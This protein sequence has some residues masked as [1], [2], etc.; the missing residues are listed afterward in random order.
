M[1]AKDQIDLLKWLVAR[2]DSMRA[3][4]SNRAAMILSADA[5]ILAAIAFLLDKSITTTTQPWHYSLK[6]FAFASLVLMTISFVLAL[7]ASIAYRHSR[8]TAHFTGPSRVFL[9]TRETFDP[10]VCPD[11]ATFKTKFDA[12]TEASFIESACAEL[13]VDL[14][15]QQIRYGRLKKS[16]LFIL[17]A[18]L[19]LVVALIIALA[20]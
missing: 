1:E 5:I 8:A 2:S 20:R 7:T 10:K 9:N 6:I 4:Y 11:F 3:T 16:V 19:S 13:W 17:G 14:R 15:L 12:L 18:F